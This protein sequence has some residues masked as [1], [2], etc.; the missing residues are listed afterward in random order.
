MKSILTL[1]VLLFTITSFAQIQVGE[2]EKRV[3]V[4]ELKPMGKFTAELSYKL[5]GR[6]TLYRLMLAN[7]K[8]KTLTD[9]YSVHFS[10]EEG[11]LDKLYSIMKSVFAK[12]NAKNKEYKVNFKLGETEVIVSNYRTT[13]I[14]FCM[15]FTTEGYTLLN[16]KSIDKLF[17]KGK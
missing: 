6:D 1:T 12:E 5:E 10:G 8:F 14:T 13:G 16:E 3:V 4:S 2:P 7:D 9:L 17:A 11:T 15:F